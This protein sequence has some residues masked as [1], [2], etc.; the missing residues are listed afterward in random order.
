MAQPQMARELTGLEV[1]L[2]DVDINSSYA[3]HS[4]SRNK[5]QIPESASENNLPSTPATNNTHDDGTATSSNL[6]S[7]PRDTSEL[8]TLR[9]A[10]KNSDRMCYSISTTY[11]TFS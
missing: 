9:N 3:I 7:L 6:C 8:I 5:S 10:G 2:T 1:D 11:R 4:Q